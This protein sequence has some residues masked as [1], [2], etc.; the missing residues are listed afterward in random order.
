M[1]VYFLLLIL[2]MEYPQKFQT[3]HEVATHGRKRSPE[4]GIYLGPDE[5]KWW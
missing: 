5:V 3:N 2:E 1:N 4:E